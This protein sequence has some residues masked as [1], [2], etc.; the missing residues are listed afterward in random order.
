MKETPLCIFLNTFHNLQ[1]APFFY[2]GKGNALETTTLKA[3]GCENVTGQE[4]GR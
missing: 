2:S 1:I 3:G 4:L